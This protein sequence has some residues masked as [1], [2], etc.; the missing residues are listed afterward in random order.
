MKYFLDTSY[1]VAITHKKDDYHDQAKRVNKNLEKP[2]ELVTS[3]AVLME[4][5]SLLSKIH[6]RKKA[7]EYIRILKQDKN[8]KIVYIDSKLFEKSLDFFKKYEDKEWS[9]VDCSSFVI[10]QEMNILNALTSDHHFEQA[11]FNIFLNP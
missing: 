9:L 5:G 3:T 8:T 4:F 7:F 1:V 10:M 2:I 11:G 6:T